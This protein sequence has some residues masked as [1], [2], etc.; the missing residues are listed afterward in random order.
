MLQ[1]QTRV[2]SRTM[3][4][5]IGHAILTPERHQIQVPQFAFQKLERLG[6]IKRDRQTGLKRISHHVYMFLTPEYDTLAEGLRQLL[7]PDCSGPV[8][9]DCDCEECK[10]L[11]QLDHPEPTSPIANINNNFQPWRK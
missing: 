2:K 9:V 1:K 5:A 8:E 10:A 6:V 11:K 3:S 4:E 7:G